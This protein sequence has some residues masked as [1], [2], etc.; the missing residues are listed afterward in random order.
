MA[1]PDDVALFVDLGSPTSLKSDR[2]LSLPSS[3]LSVSTADSST[4]PEANDFQ[5]RRRRAAKLTQFFGVDYK[6]VMQEVLESIEKGVED[7][8]QS[9]TLQPDE[10]E[11]CGTLH[12]TALLNS[13]C[14]C[15]PCR[16]CSKNYDS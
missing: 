15:S 1:S 3:I 10:A 9:G 6:S 7:E 4:R 2:R 11:V 14:T 5:L 16:L 13:H 8:R 12:H